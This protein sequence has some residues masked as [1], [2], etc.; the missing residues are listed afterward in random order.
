MKE[1]FRKQKEC[2]EYGKNIYKWYKKEASEFCEYIHW[3]IL[4]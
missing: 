1:D 3:K 4:T 2:G